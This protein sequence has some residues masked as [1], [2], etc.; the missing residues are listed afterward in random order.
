MYLFEEYLIRNSIEVPYVKHTQLGSVFYRWNNSW[1]ILQIRFIENSNHPGYYQIKCLEPSGHRYDKSG[2]DRSGVSLRRVDESQ[3]YWDQY[4]SFFLNWCDR[5]PEVATDEQAK[6]AAWEMC[7]YCFDTLLLNYVNSEDFYNAL[8]PDL[9]FERRCV[10]I[11]RVYGTIRRDERNSKIRE[12]IIK[13]WEGEMV[14]MLK[15]YLEWLVKL[16]EKR[17]SV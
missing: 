15:Y 8:N 6:V 10:F 2:S 9:S 3:I 13:F 7:I 12:P 5:L 16:V 17:R 11:D 1:R 4:Q 14:P